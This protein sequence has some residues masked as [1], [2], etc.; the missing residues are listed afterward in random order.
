VKVIDC[1]LYRRGKACLRGK[2]ECFDG[3][4]KA[5]LALRKGISHRPIT[6]QINDE[7]A[8]WRQRLFLQ[9]FQRL[10]KVFATSAN[11]QNRIDARAHQ[12]RLGASAQTAPLTLGEATPNAKALVV[13]ESVFQTFGFHLA[14]A[15]NLLGI[16]GGATFFGEKRFRVRLGTQRIGLPGKGALFVFNASHTGNA[17]SDGVNEPVIGNGIPILAH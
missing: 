15:A 11:N 13:G 8:L 16:P 2:G 5:P 4:R 3:K 14:L 7:Q 10:R 1:P 17:Q 12:N 9:A 6:G